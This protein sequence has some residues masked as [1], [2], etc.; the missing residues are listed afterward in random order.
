METLSKE[1]PQN[2]MLLNSMTC[3]IPG[4]GAL[5]GSPSKTGVD[6]ISRAVLDDMVRQSIQDRARTS[7]SL[8]P[9]T[10]KCI[11]H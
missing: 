6:L 11:S 2:V 7:Y 5:I 9:D 3:V 8:A 1:Y 10:I 4:K